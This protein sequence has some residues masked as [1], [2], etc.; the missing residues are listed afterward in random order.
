MIHRDGFRRIRGR[1]IGETATNERVGD[2]GNRTPGRQGVRLSWKMWL[3][4]TMRWI[5]EVPS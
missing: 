4:M 2:A 1:L 5:S 3:E